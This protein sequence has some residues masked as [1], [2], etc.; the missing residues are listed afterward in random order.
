MTTRAD[1][2]GA[3]DVYTSTGTVRK[4]GLIYTSECGWIDLGHA[5][6]DGKTYECARSLWQQI[7]RQTTYTSCLRDR[8]PARIKYGQ[9]MK[10]RGI[11]IGETREYDVDRELDSAEEQKS[12]ALSIFLD[13]SVAFESL[14]S[15]WFFRHVSDSGYSVEDLV[16]NLVGFYR[17]VN[18][19][20]DYISICKPVPKAHALAI[21]DE[22]GAVGSRKNKTT[23]PVLFPNPLVECGLVRTGR[24]PH[25]L[26]TI[27]PATIGKKFRR[28][29]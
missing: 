26:D 12:I 8:T 4:Y 6:S 13:V 29:R 9:T 14:Q 28:A 10:R 11:S 19:G 25:M 2:I 15:N 16:S 27:K 22:F 17:A 20:V 23:S 21:W 1:I 5:N 24:L 3:D 7:T 18:P